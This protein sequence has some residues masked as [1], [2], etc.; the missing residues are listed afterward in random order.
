MGSF[1]G[2]DGCP[3]RYSNIRF[4]LKVRIP[5][6]L[7]RLKV[8]DLTIKICNCNTT[9]TE[10]PSSAYVLL[11][12][13]VKKNIT[14]M[15]QPSNTSTTPA[16]QE[17]TLPDNTEELIRMLGLDEYEE[18]NEKL[19]DNNVGNINFDPFTSSGLIEDLIGFD[20][21]QGY[22]LIGNSMGSYQQNEIISYVDMD[23]SPI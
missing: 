7:L 1:G 22:Q 19:M 17:T 21:N 14:K 4:L 9:I 13:L 8:Q 3:Y 10:V 2:C 11:L 18:N 5:Y 20:N 16:N 6:P 15:D 23:M 12:H